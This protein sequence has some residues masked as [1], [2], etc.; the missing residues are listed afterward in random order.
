MFGQIIRWSLIVALWRKYKRHVYSALL[1][2]VGWIIVEI[3][4]QDFVQYVEVSKQQSSPSLAWSFIAKWL[5]NI[6]F[7]FLAWLYLKRQNRHLSSNSDLHK[8]MR[9]YSDNSAS[10]RHNKTMDSLN[11]SKVDPFEKIRT[12]KQLRSKADVIIDNKKN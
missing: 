4:H 1:V 6:I 7:I 11:D 8:D 5:L 12:K 3:L 9:Q 10:E 2:I